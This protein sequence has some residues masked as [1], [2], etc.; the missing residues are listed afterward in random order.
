M[1]RRIVA[2]V[3]LPDGSPACQLECGH[4][5]PLHASFLDLRLV[6]GERMMC[7][8]CMISGADTRKKWRRIGIVCL[9]WA[10]AFALF[11]VAMCLAVFR[12]R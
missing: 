10:G 2:D 8:E 1:W 6:G 12:E 3:D 9:V 5:L 4:V 7:E 11:A